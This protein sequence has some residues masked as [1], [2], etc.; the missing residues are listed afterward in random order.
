VARL[1]KA[2]LASRERRDAAIRFARLSEALIE[3]TA[4]ESGLGEFNRRRKAAGAEPYRY[5]KRGKRK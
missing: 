5:P 1:T 4:R 2:E 3:R